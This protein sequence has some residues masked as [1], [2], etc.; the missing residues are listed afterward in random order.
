[1]GGKIEIRSCFFFF[2]NILGIVFAGLFIL[3][4]R[5]CGKYL[6]V[7]LGWMNFSLKQKWKTI[8][9]EKNKFE[10]LQQLVRKLKYEY[11]FA[12]VLNYLG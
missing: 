6:F 1:M 8:N 3:G 4:L 7:I 2:F 11:R 9:R 10:F 5:I 12:V